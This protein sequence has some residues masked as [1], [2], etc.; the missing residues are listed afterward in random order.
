M[1]LVS[2]VLP[3][4]TNLQQNCVMKRKKTTTKKYVDSSGAHVFVK[5]LL[6]FQSLDNKTRKKKRSL[7]LMNNTQM[8][9]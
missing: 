2:M 1:P 9:K 5:T 6:F 8:H 4:V 3:V 7:T